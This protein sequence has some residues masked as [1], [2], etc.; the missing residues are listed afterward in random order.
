[1]KTLNPCG[2]AGKKRR[3]DKPHDSREHRG[4]AGHFTEYT[5]L[6]ASRER[7]LTEFANAEFKDGGLTTLTYNS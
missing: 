4:L 7:I 5:L 2:E 1:M 3:E 6:T